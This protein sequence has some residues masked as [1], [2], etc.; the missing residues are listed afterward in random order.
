MNITCPVLKQN[1]GTI[2]RAIR[3]LVGL[4]ALVSGFMWFTGTAQIVLYVAGAA[5]IF[6]GVVGFCGLYG[7]LGI[8]TKRIARKA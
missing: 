7:L 5:A 2:D 8:T 4:M 6:T 1:E 3:V